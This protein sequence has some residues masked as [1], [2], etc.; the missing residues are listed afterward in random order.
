MW[1]LILSIYTYGG[2]GALNAAAIDHIDGF[3][4]AK[5]CAEAGKSW[6]EQDENRRFFYCVHR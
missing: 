2:F 5:A 1:I 4:T 6:V 3:E